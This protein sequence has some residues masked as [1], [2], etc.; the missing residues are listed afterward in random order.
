MCWLVRAPAH[1]I[2][3][4]SRGIKLQEAG[5]NVGRPGTYGGIDLFTLDRS[6][7]LPLPRSPELVP[8]S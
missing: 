3:P 4:L 6:M 5:V 2:F 8:M 1:F 7:T